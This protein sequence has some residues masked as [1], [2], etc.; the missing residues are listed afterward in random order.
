[1]RS[2]LPLRIELREDPKAR[3]G[4]LLRVLAALL[5]SR[6][7]DVLKQRKEQ[8]KKDQ[9]ANTQAMPA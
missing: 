7:W 4:D 9:P 5:L 3:P 6:S 8:E 1:M 2:P